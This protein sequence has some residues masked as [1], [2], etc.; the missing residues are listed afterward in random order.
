MSQKCEQ[1]S[2]GLFVFRFVGIWGPKWSPYVGEASRRI[3]PVSQIV[4]LTPL[5]SGCAFLRLRTR[6][7]I[8]RPL[9]NM[10]EAPIALAT[11][12]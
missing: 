2:Y 10:C 6:I 1:V 7:H 12:G 9:R 8:R 4:Y 5:P 3:G 11:G